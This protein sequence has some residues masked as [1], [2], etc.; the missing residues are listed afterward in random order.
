M[1]VVRLGSTAN[2]GKRVIARGKPTTI[3]NA[4]RSDPIQRQPAR[5]LQFHNFR[6][7]EQGRI[8]AG[9]RA[10]GPRRSATEFSTRNRS[11]PSDERPGYEGGSQRTV[12]LDETK[13]NLTSELIHPQRNGSS[14]GST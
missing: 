8:V 3:A 13:M 4:K 5:W 6:V 1:V 12:A 9:N 14:R 7:L 2:C 11:R 10:C